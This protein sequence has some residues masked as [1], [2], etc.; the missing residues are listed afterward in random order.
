MILWQF[1]NRCGENAGVSITR[2]LTPLVSLVGLRPAGRP[3]CAADARGDTIH[4]RQQSASSIP[5]SKI[6]TPRFKSPSN[7]DSKVSTDYVASWLHSWASG[8]GRTRPSTTIHQETLTIQPPNRIRK[9]KW[10][11]ENC[12]WP[13]GGPDCWG[14]GVGTTP[15]TTSLSIRDSFATA[16]SP[17]QPFSP[18]KPPTHFSVINPHLM[19]WWIFA[20]W[21]HRLYTPEPKVIQTGFSNRHT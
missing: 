14:D 20:L 16:S 8:R 4:H 5:R 6:P 17:L 18:R 11:I 12:S 13:T 15:S 10:K 19:Y 3:D 21:N 2:R 1:D 7:W 9:K